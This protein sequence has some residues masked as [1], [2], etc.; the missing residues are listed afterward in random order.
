[1]GKKKSVEKAP[2]VDAEAFC[3]AD[4]LHSDAKRS[5]AAVFLFAFSL[6][7]ILGYF[8]AAGTLGGWLNQGMG[9]LFGC[10]KWP[11]PL[12]L[13]VAGGMLLTRRATSVADAVKYV[14]LFVAFAAL[15]G[16][17]HL[18]S[19]QDVDELMRFAREGKGGGFVGFGLSALFLS[20]TGKLAGGILL[21]MLLLIGIIAAFNVS[22]MHWFEWIATRVKRESVGKKE[23]DH[24]ADEFQQAETEVDRSDEEDSDALEALLPQKLMHLDEDRLL[25]V[26]ELAEITPSTKEPIANKPAAALLAD[27]NIENVRFHETAMT[28]PVIQEA[29]PVSREEDS[30]WEVEDEGSESSGEELAPGPLVKRRRRRTRP[31]WMLPKADLLETK[32]EEAAGGDTE[33]R[34][35]L[36]MSTLKNFGIVVE[37]GE[38]KI[39]PTVTQYTFRPGVGVKLSRIT[40]LSTNLALALAAESLR[41]EAPIPGQSYIGIEIPNM[42]KAIVRMRE[43]VEDRA[44]RDTKSL[45]TLGIGQDVTGKHVFA[46]LGEMPHLLIAGRTKS[47]KSVCVN[48]ILTSLLYKHSPD[49]LKLILVDP[50]RVELSMYKG[51]PHLKTEVVVDGKKVVNALSWAIGEM[52][53]RYKL[54]EAV[55]VRDL[56]AYQALCRDGY[57]KIDTDERTGEMREV[58]L[59]VLPFIVIII[60]ELAEIMVSYGKEVEPKI[61]RLAQMSRAVGIHLVLAT[62]RPS[63]EVITGL[64]KTNLPTRIAFQVS[65][66]VDSRTILDTGG[67][68]KLLGNGDMLYVSPSGDTQRLQGVYISTEEVHRVT[69]HWRNEKAAWGEEDSLDD[70]I[71]A[72]PNDEGKGGSGEGSGKD[73]LFEQARDLFIRSQKAST[74]SLQTAFGIGYPRAAR[75]MHILEEEGVVGTMDGKKQIL[76]GRDMVSASDAAP[77]PEY[78]DDPLRDQAQREKWQ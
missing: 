11:L 20:F 58:E 41:I 19:G 77:A 70:D 52:E 13:L 75:L 9:L 24:Q 73:E 21:G 48:A 69:T 74:T 27:G 34:K 56:P 76:I 30:E 68:E 49:E 45:L 72:G 10:G 54:L 2:E 8:G 57:R 38:V 61:V 33:K 29:S 59:E 31:N 43:I 46:D 12:I 71:T 7:I 39:G 17:L 65:S 42:S 22:L 36:I 35:H 78:G 25:E 16:L 26:D 23:A 32:S 1:M 18:W 40:A 5:I 55:H 51:I 50:K 62:Q 3:F 67:A 15:L 66:Q 60:D 6:V 14:G 47:G 53:R 44:F 4:V 28:T 37:A 63:V 64:I